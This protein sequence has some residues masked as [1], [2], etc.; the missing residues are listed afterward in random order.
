MPLEHRLHARCGCAAASAAEEAGHAG[1]ARPFAF[2]STQ[3]HFER[4]RPFAI[5]HL[6][7]ALTLDVAAKRVHG[8]ATL[9]VRRIDPEAHE[10]ALDAVGFELGAVK[11]NGKTAAPVYDGRTLLVPLGKLDAAKVT[12]A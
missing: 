12:V 3:R 9:D 1:G 2:A 7:L 8:T 5:D 4:A 11:V 10:I 6:A